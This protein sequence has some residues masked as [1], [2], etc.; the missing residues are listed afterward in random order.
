[1][2]HILAGATILC[3]ENLEEKKNHALWIK[4]KRFHKIIPEVEI[5]TDLMV[6]RLNGGYLVPGLID[7][8][9]HLMWDGSANPV[10][11][12]NNESYEQKLIR[13][14]HHAQQYVKHGITT[15]RDLGSIDDISLHVAEAINRNVITGTRIIASGKTLTMTGGHDPFWARFC[16][17]KNEALK[18]VREQI[19]KNAR[20]IKVSAT[21]GVYGRAVGEAAENAELSYEELKVIVD[22]AHR[23]GLKVASHAIGR[24][25]IFNSIRAGVD[26]IEHG[27][28]LDEELIALMLEKQTA[29]VPTLYVYKQIAEI[30]GIPDYAK[31]KARKITAIHKE[32]FMTYFKSGVLV[33]AG[34][35]AGSCLTPHPSVIE[36]L[37]LMNQFYP[38]ETKSILKTATV[39]AG[40]ILGMEVGQI[41]EGFLADLI[42]VDSNP[43]ENLNALKNVQRIFMDGKQVV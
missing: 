39:N 19:Y 14:V 28:Y 37:E 9:V 34:S 42:H 13:A 5:P 38:N 31:E 11:T 18:G 27:H 25:G 35:D 3:G 16:D 1:M 7:L 30:D 43:L 17:G 32:A 6:T 21:G 22:E 33:G 2:E 15:V 4:N 23:F 8:H 24:Q 26:S 10:Q 40:K 41:Q 36:E 29:W 20:V 12:Q